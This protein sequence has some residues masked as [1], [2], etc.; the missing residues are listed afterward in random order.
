VENF[1][2]ASKVNPSHQQCLY[3]LGIVYRFDLQDIP[4]AI[5]A[6]EQFLALNPG[7]PAAEQVRADLE[8]LKS[9]P[10]ARQ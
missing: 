10:T 5:D 7:G 6:W 8:Q 4:K 1:Q 9:L 3:N 2:K